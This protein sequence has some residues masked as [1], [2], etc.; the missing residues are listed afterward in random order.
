MAST[1]QAGTV[2]GGGQNVTVSEVA[3]A[4]LVLVRKAAG[5]DLAAAHVLVDRHAA[6]LYGLAMRLTGNSSDA[7]DVLQEAYVRAFSALAN[8]RGEASLATWLSRIVLNEALQRL[9]GQRNVTLMAEVPEPKMDAQV[10][11]FP[12]S[13]NQILDPEKSMAQRE[14]FA[15][16][17]QAIDQL[18]DDFRLVLMARTI[19]GMSIEETAELL[20]LKPETVKTRLFRARALLRT[21]LAEHIGPLFTDA[22]PF[23]G[24]RCES[25]AEAVVARLAKLN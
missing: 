7:E 23:D 17:E 14:L 25:M 22:F 12:L 13:S 11:P 10:I 18:P 3:A 2:Q 9:R 6:K 8:F 21:A 20:G 1:G 5:G 15:L 16:L 19:E 4:E 24:R